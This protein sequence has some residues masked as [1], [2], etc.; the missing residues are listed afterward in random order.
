M[1]IRNSDFKVKL[2]EGAVKEYEKIVLSSGVCDLFMPMGFVTCEEGEIVSYNCSGYTALRQC[3]ITEIREAFEIL[4]KTFLLVS[5]AGEYL[6]TPSRITLSL[7]TIFYNRKTKQVKIA[8]VPIGQKSVTLRENMASFITQMEQGLQGNGRAYLSAVKREMEENNYYIG[9]LINI[10][11][12]MRRKLTGYS[13]S[14]HKE[15]AEQR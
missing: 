7:D 9:D 14:D 11:G 12:D 2:K 15:G 6:I 13:R 4:E 8:Y 1:E 10:I 3:N 5:H